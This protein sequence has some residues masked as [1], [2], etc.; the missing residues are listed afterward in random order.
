[1]D[2]TGLSL[3]IIQICLLKRYQDLQEDYSNFNEMKRVESEIFEK[4]D[5][6]LP[7]AENIFHYVF[8]PVIAEP[9][10]I[11]VKHI[12][13]AYVT[14]TTGAMNLFL[15]MNLFGWNLKNF[16]HSSICWGGIGD[17]GYI[18]TRRTIEDATTFLIESSK[19]LKFYPNEPAYNK[20]YVV[21]LNSTL[22]QL[23]Q[24]NNTREGWKF[25]PEIF[26]SF[27]F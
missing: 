11:I 15:L 14:K 26:N 1:M 13:E 24:S 8:V 3:L 7:P 17:I 4:E 12:N 18:F 16:V 6:T 22:K 10:D 19:K 21:L 23:L 27:I 5:S 20:L 2:Q 9:Q 25:T